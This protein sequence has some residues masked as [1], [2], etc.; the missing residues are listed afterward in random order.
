MRAF[1]L[2]VGFG[3]FIAALLTGGLALSG[4]SNLGTETLPNFCLASVLTAMA[5]GLARSGWLLIAKRSL[6]LPGKARVLI[7]LSIC[8]FVGFVLAF[9]IPSFVA[10]SLGRGPL[11][12]SIIF[13]RLMGQKTNGRLKMGKPTAMFAPKT[14]SSPTSNLIQTG[15]YQNVHK[16]A[17]TPLAGLAKIRN[18]LSG[19][20]IGRTPTLLTIKA[21]GG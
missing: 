9:V 5:I 16:A 3:C 13:V 1:K 4:F 2:I 21:V 18:V 11:D 19:F 7:A 10:A 8:L 17:H 15:I 12:A 14:T 6:P 20:T